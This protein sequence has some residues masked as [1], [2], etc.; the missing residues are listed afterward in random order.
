MFLTDDYKDCKTLKTAKQMMF[1]NHWPVNDDDK[2]KSSIGILN[3]SK[4]YVVKNES[5][6]IGFIK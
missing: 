2:K 4:I 3:T 6:S 5:R 1:V